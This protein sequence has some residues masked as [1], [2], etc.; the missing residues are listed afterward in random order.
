MRNF[1]SPIGPDVT[2]RIEDRL[3]PQGL[4]PRPCRTDVDRSRGPHLGGRH[5]FRGLT[6]LIFETY[7]LLRLPHAHLALDHPK[8]TAYGDSLANGDFGARR[9]NYPPGCVAIERLGRT[10]FRLYATDFRGPYFKKGASGPFHSDTRRPRS[11]IRSE[12]N[13]AASS[14]FLHLRTFPPRNP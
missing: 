5:A 11:Q 4:A 1:A 8:S 9:M 10:G 7:R 13:V 3:G 2:Q 6:V 12:E 14:G